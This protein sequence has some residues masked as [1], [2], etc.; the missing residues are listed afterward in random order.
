MV[1]TSATGLAPL[2]DTSYRPG[3]AFQSDKDANVVSMP[4]G[5]KAAISRPPLSRFS[6]AMEAPNW[7]M[8][9]PIADSFGLFEEGQNDLFDFLP[10]MPSMPQ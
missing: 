5:D 10:M 2:E 7:T 1:T 4:G 9:N 6:G 3:A 8:S